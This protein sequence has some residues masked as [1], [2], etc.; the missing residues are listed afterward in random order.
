[1]NSAPR[2][3]SAVVELL[4]G[5]SAVAPGLLWLQASRALVAAD[6]HFG[7]ENVIGAALPAWSTAEIAATLTQTA[8]RMQAREILLLGDVIHGSR[9]S[10]SAARAVRGVLS[11]LREIA[12][13]TLIAGNHEG[14]SRGAQILG[15]TV[16]LAQ[17]DGWTL[18]HGDKAPRAADLYEAP[19]CII[20]HLH[21]SLALGGGATAPAFLASHRLIVVPALT[22]YSSGLDALSVAFMDAVRPFGAATRADFQIVAAAGE[23]L[24]PF[25]SVSQLLGVRRK[26]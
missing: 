26:R 17:R 13:L 12:Q 11:G 7:Y 6:V 18:L 3:A 23:L 5:V 15:E 24:Y 1:M 10:E 14:R 20:G 2:P 25:G 8:R 4:P 21:P 16:E 22:P 19:R 9:M